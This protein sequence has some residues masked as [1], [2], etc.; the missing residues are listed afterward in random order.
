MKITSLINLHVIKLN[1]GEYAFSSFSSE[2]G[3]S[4]LHIRVE[5]KV[6]NRPVITT[7]GFSTFHPRGKLSGSK[8]RGWFVQPAGMM[9]SLGRLLHQPTCSPGCHSGRDR[10]PWDYQTSLVTGLGPDVG[11]ELAG[12]FACLLRLV[13]RS[14]LM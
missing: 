3:C 9:A 14:E 13:N 10:N 7:D 12:W 1:H 5:K 2:A 4:G 11:R 8:S 6:L